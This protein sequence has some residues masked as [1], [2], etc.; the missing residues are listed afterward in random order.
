M[1]QYS[2][3]GRVFLLV[4]NDFLYNKIY[5]IYFLSIIIKKKFLNYF[6][7]LFLCWVVVVVV[8]N[9]INLDFIIKYIKEEKERKKIIIEMIFASNLT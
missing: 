8:V 9:I 5:I 4:V 7:F 3:D 6:L 1:N 2:T